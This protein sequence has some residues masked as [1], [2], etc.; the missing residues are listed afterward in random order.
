MKK[1]Y[2]EKRLG[3]KSG[4]QNRTHIVK[5]HISADAQGDFSASIA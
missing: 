5:P 3:F 4:A 2:L 1:V